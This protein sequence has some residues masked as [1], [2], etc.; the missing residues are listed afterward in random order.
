MTF[1]HLFDLTCRTAL[2]LE[3]LALRWRG[4]RLP[5]AAGLYG[6]HARCSSVA[7]VQRRARRRSSGARSGAKQRKLRQREDRTNLEVV[8]KGRPEWFLDVAI[9]Y[10]ILNT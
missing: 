1:Q 4:K 7:A 6:W 9:R 5:T 2:L 10:L 8:L 3:V